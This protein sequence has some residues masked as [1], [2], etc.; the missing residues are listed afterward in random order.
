M[1]EFDVIAQDPRTRARAGRFHTPHGVVETPAFMP[2]GTQA[3]VKALDPTELRDV[4]SQMILANTYHLAQRPGADVVERLGG[5]HGFMGWDGPI[6]TDSGGFQVWSLSLRSAGRPLVQIDDDGATFRSHLDGALR[7]FTPESAVDLQSRLGADV[8]MAFDECTASDADEEYARAA[9]ERTHRWA[10]RCRERWKERQSSRT[11]P[12]ALFGIVQGGRFRDLRRWSAETILAL[13]LPGIAIGGESIGYS[14]ERTIEILDWIG[15]LLPSD[16]PRY[17]MGIGDP[18]DFLTAIE[19]GIDLF[20]SVYPTRLARNGALLHRG[21]RLRIQSA[22]YRTDEGP[23][24][25]GCRCLACRTFSRAY[26]HH[27]FRAREL[28]GHRLATLH[29]LTYC[30]DLVADLRQALAGGMLSAFRE[31]WLPNAVVAG[32]RS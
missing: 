13:D 14:K 18:A 19:R 9:A 1:F 28:L 24:D 2:V 4:G 5:L 7:R 11:L 20:D 29:N 15:D 26:L 32:G 17:A 30:L 23:I 25:P 8:I 3:A 6:L 31:H 16:R 27:L 22:A 21:G 10:R 12:Q